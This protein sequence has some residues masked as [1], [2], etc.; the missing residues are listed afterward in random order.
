MHHGSACITDSED[1]NGARH[2]ACILV[3]VSKSKR[4]DIRHHLLR[5][6]VLRGKLDVVAVESEQQRADFLT[7]ALAGP[8][9]RLHRYFAMNV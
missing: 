4:I 6:L 2:L 5:E 8:D 9:F 1:S 7:K 3:C